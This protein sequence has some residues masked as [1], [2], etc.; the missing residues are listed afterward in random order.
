METPASLQS[1]DINRIIEAC[2]FH[3]QPTPAFQAPNTPFRALAAQNGNSRFEK[4]EATDFRGQASIPR[5]LPA[6]TDQDM[7]D[8]CADLSSTSISSDDDMDIDL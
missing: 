7:G 5:L 4:I 6:P 1:E 3:A 8:L 2:A